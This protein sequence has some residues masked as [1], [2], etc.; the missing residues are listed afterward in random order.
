M[1]AAGAAGTPDRDAPDPG[2]QLVGV[3]QL[4]EMATSLEERLLRHVL[5]VR[6]RA[7]GARQS[8]EVTE[9]RPVL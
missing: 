2:P 8:R 5:G 6:A 9:Q 4:V 3:A 7:K 1:P